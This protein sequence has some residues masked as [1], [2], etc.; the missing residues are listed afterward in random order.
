MRSILIAMVLAATSTATIAQWYP[1]SDPRSSNYQQYLQQQR[2]EFNKRQRDEEARNKA[3][4]EEMYGQKPSSP[5]GGS[6]AGTGTDMR[7]LGKELMRLPPLPVERNVLLGSWRLEGGGPR[8]GAAEFAITGRGATPGLGEMMGMLGDMQSGKMIC[9]MSFGRGITFT[10][11]TFSSGGAAGIAEGPIAYRSRKKQVIVAIPGDTR[12]N[13]MPFTIAGPNRIVWADT[14]ALVRV[15]TTAANAAANATTASGNARTAA[16]NSSAPPAA[17]AM[18]QVAA[19]EPA[20]PRSTLSRPSPEV[21]RN[22]FLDQLGKV[23]VNQV[24]AMSDVRFREPAIEGKVPNTNNLRLD[25]RGSACDDPR[26]KATLYDFDADGVLQS[27]MLVWDRPA[28]PAP[29]PIFTE[30]VSTLSRFHPLPP[31]QSSGRLQADTSLGRL[32]LQDL[33]ERN[34]LLEEYKAK[35]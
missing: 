29:A 19:V 9:D 27:I 15:G 4:A 3:H 10:P 6:S 20:A 34:L 26:I 5:S 25:L 12:A 21:C 17:G 2:D 14:C 7:A 32:I 16:A 31:P 13:P 23:G 18:P 33:P 11:T 24:R 35:K 1:D 22:K 8:S 30:R 28:G